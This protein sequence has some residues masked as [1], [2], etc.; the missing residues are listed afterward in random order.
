MKLFPS[1]VPAINRDPSRVG[2]GFKPAPTTGEV[3]LAPRTHVEPVFFHGG[4]GW[5][6]GCVTVRG[7][8][9]SEP[10]S[11]VAGIRIDSRL[12]EIF[13]TPPRVKLDLLKNQ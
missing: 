9:G 8:S 4:G 6:E 12:V 13:Y 2:A 7:R 3:E 11:R 1:G 10:E 5:A